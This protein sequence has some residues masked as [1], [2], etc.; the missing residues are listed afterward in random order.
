MLLT[1]EM[2]VFLK[3][4]HLQNKDED[5]FNVLVEVNFEGLYL[6]TRLELY[7]TICKSCLNGELLIKFGVRLV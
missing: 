7:L 5:V 4:K 2:L 6:L 3:G 1:P